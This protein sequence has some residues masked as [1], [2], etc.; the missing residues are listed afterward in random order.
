MKTLSLVVLIASISAPTLAAA[1]GDAAAGAVQFDR[2][3]KSC[4]VV[5]ND[6]GEVLAGGSAKAGPNLYGLAGKTLGSVEGFRYGDSLA[7]AGDAGFVWNEDS[8]VG[9]IQNPT[10]WLVATLGDRRARGKMA[11]QVRDKQQAHDIYA[12]ITSF[13]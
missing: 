6:S 12:F 9:Y 1:E 13:Q 5:R 8:F 10:N 11:Y 4:H 3:C 7:A 2:Q